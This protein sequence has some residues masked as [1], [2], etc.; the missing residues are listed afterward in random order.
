MKKRSAL[1]I[2]V[3]VCIIALSSC[4][5]I[6]NKGEELADTAVAIGKEFADT[7]VAMGKELADTASV[8]GQQYAKAAVNEVI[9][10]FDAYTPDT[11]YNKERYTEFILDTLTPDVKNI[12]CFGDAM[13][14]DANYQFSFNCNATTAQKIIKAHELKAD[15]TNTM[16]GFRDDFEWWDTEKIKTLDCYTW[17]GEHR[18]FTHFWY[19]TKEQKAYFNTYDM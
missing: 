5:R 9:P 10:M 16:Y 17:E 3:T 18:Y 6:K 1:L 7:A 13:G 19:D 14:I 4:N 2:V 11:K 8:R 15:S 12:Y